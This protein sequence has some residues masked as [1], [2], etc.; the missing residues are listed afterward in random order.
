MSRVINPAPLPLARP[1]FLDFLLILLG[2]SLSRFLYYLAGPTIRPLEHIPFEASPWLPNLVVELVVL[3][4]GIV[5]LWPLFYALQWLRGRPQSL[6]AG[7]WLWGVA[8]IGTVL[9]LGLVAWI[10]SGSAPEFLAKATFPPQLIWYFV[11]GP[12]MALI[13]LIILMVDLVGRWPQPW[14]HTF[15]LALMVWPALPLTA[16]LAWR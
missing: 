15:S 7:E 14:T 10:N 6:S 16:V 5:L 11:V 12:S 8:W 9:Y 1:T 13:A 2:C 3:P 4:Q